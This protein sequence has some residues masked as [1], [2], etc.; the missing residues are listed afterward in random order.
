VQ[1]ACES[2]LSKAEAGAVRNKSGDPYKPSVIRSYETSLRLH[3]FPEIGSRKL[4]R[5]RRSELQ[6]L[7]DRLQLARSA[8]TVRN[9]MMPLRAVFRRAVLL[10]LVA[11]NATIGLALPSVTGSRDRVASPEEAA[12]L[13]QA[14]P[15]A[16]RAAW[17]TAMYA[18]LRLGELRALEWKSVDLARGLIKIEFGWDPKKGR[19]LPKSSSGRRSVAIPGVLMPYL[20]E[21]QTITGRRSGLVFGRSDTRPFCDSSLRDR[22]K[23]IWTKQSMNPIGFHEA[24]HTYATLMIAAGVNAKTLST[25]MGHKS[26]T[27]TLDLYGHL[28]PGAESE[29]G[30]SLDAYLETV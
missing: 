8:S 11:S 6:V 3:V 10:D 17:A 14:L 22:A 21:Q 13:L 7:V 1:E 12:A 5:V 20:E 30:A 27:I 25:M 29:A 23:R 18:G 28:F 19:I 4:S 16:D 15:E 2:W 9:A 24:R 26:I